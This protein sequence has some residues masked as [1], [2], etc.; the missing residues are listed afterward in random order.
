MENHCFPSYCSLQT[1]SREIPTWNIIDGLLNLLK[2][3]VR[4]CTRS[5]NPRKGPFIVF[6]GVDGAGKTFHMDVIQEFLVNIQ[7]PVHKLVFPNGQTKLGRFLKTCMREARHLDVWT[8]HVLF[9]IHRWEF[10]SWMTDILEKGEAILCERYVWS[11]LVYSCALAPGLDIRTFMCTDMGLMAP[12]MVIYVDTPP[13]AVRARPQM[14]A[15]FSDLEFQNQIYDLYQE[16]SIWD[17]I[18]V[19]RHRTSDNKWESRQRLTS[20][21]RGDPSGKIPIERGIICGKTQDNVQCVM[22]VLMRRKNVN[23]VWNV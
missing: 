13:E 21:I 8:Q 17:G 2:P 1:W 5:Q 3:S 12:D 18:R 10:M 23:A 19:V 16:T 20:V 6:E 4:R 11:G 9:S 7:Y 15:L 22:S 14:S